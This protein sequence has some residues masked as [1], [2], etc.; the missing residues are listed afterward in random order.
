MFPTEQ[1][2]VA[3]VRTEKPKIVG[4]YLESLKAKKDPPKE[5]EAPK[6]PEPAVVKQQERE[7]KVHPSS[8]PL[9][10]TLQ[11]LIAT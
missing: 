9:Q 8:V 10:K 3:P 6:V 2:P 4:S 1:E 11:N 5:P 7:K